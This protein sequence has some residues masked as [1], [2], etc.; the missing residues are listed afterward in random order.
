[1]KTTLKLTTLVLGVTLCGLG[2]LAQPEPGERP[3]G[4]P[5]GDDRGLPPVLRSLDIDRDGRLS[6]EEIATATAV[7][8][9]WEREG[10]RVA[11]RETGRGPGRRAAAVGG[12]GPADGP[13]REGPARRDRNAEPDLRER[14]GQ[15]ERGPAMAEGDAGAL[16]RREAARQEGG[17]RLLREQ[18]EPRNQG[19]D[20]GERGLAPGRRGPQGRGAALAGPEREGAPGRGPRQFERGEPS[21]RWMQRPDADGRDWQG[22]PRG[23]FSQERGRSFA[24][25]QGQGPGGPRWAPADGLGAGGRP[26]G[27]RWG[28]G[29]GVGPRFECPCC[30]QAHRG[31]G[32]A[33]RRPEGNGRGRGGGP[34]RG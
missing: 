7:L 12:S 6:E 3:P 29:A 15:V 26:R 10:D 1:M 31:P 30:G 33:G 4:N 2:A 14:G 25:S 34:G 20:D 24:R 16:R 23:R 22:P 28:R 13:S 18:A 32:P 5:G 11:E 27:E 9:R 21:A 17:R 8:K 19:P